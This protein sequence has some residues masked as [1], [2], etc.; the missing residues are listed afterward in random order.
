MRM[1]GLSTLTRRLLVAGVCVAALA[2]ATTAG[3]FA[4]GSPAAAVSPAVSPAV[5]NCTAAT[6]TF[7]LAVNPGLATGKP[8]ACPAI[9]QATATIS[10][11]NRFKTGAL[12]DVLTLTAHK[13][14]PNTGFDLFLVQHSAFDTGF[15]NFG[16]GWYQSDVESN[17]SGTATVTVRGIFDH[18]T[19][20]LNPPSS[21]VHTFNVGFW[22]DSP[23]AEATVCHSAT[24]AATPFNGEQNAGLLAMI[25]KGAPLGLIH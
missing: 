23:K 17:A 16:F 12:N 18:E 1:S 11:T 13:L 8:F 5:A 21:A 24:P 2:I 10:V 15:S 20:V 14:P 9:A 25:T 3:A 4:S 22:F 6:C 7:P 19:F